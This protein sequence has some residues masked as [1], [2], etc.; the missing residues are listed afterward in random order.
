MMMMMKLLDADANGRKHNAG[1]RLQAI[2]N[3]VE[4]NI[5]EIKYE[6]LRNQDLPT[7]IT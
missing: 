1:I 2:K 5:Y 3:D 7:V 6:G 4:D